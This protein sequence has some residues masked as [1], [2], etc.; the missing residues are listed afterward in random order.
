MPNMN[1]RRQ[2]ILSALRE[3]TATGPVTLAS[4]K[5]SDFYIDARLVTLQPIVSRLIGLLVYDLMVQ[6]QLD[7]I[8]GPTTA[9]CPIVSAAGVIAASKALPVK[10]AYVRK[11]AKGHG[12]GKLIE[13]P[14]V[15]SGDSVLLVDDVL[16]SGGSLCRALDA[17]RATGAHVSRAF[18]LVDRQEG[19]MD[20]L[21]EN[22]V[23][24]SAFTT[25]EELRG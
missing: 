4:G 6:W 22:G 23:E 19:G 10:L 8:A 3:A 15:T 5:V 13:G 1:L 2:D 14:P 20:K 24:V 16:T 18:V 21:L 25:K 11:E 9:A 17:V 7:T 12:M